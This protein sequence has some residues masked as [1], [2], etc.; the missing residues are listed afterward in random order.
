MPILFLV[1]FVNVVGFGIIV[2]LLPFY[3]EH[4]G[5]D[6]FLVGLVM[7]SYSLAQFVASPLWGRFGDRG[8][9]RPAIVT[10]FLGAAA[11][12][13]GLAFA[14]DLWMLFAA[15][16]AGGLLDG[17]LASAF[18]YAADVTPRAGRARGMGAVGAAFG[19]GF[20]VGPGIGGWLAGADPTRADF[21]TPSLAAA[22]LSLLACALAFFLLEE[23]RTRSAEPPQA[24]G[25]AARF[26]ALG[27][28]LG[29]RE[30]ALP[31]AI[32]FLST[33]VFASLESTFAMWSRRQF[34]WGPEQNGYLFAF[35]GGL[36]VL[37]QGGLIGRLVKRFGE[38]SLVVQGSMALALGLALIPLATEL[39]LL[40]AAMSIAGCGFSLIMPALSSMIS[41]ASPASQQGTVMGVSRS[42]STLGR[43]IG[44]VWGGLLFSALGKDWPY[45]FGF[46]VMAVVG[47]VAAR[48][49]RRRPAAASSVSESRPGDEKTGP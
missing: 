25:L 38:A 47:L 23:S 4:F 28:L 21:Q 45:Y 26:K 11:A 16:V 14:Q 17:T 30:L 40:V 36:G 20:I 37:V 15:R 41:L 12:Y 2:P 34:G 48:G 32:S 33:L 43:V 18:A 13:V 24:R 29:R 46:A 5:A 44:S 10:G 3:A 39:P 1:V 8:G 9:R 7:A 19:L 49:F 35:V 42:A 27:A 31:L 22:G 6:P